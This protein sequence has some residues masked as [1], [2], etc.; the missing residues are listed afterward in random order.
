MKPTDREI[1]VPDFEQMENVGEDGGQT[2]MSNCD[3]TVGEGVE[4]GLR[5]GKW[6]RYAGWNFNGL[7]WFA[8]GQFH[9][10]PWTYH[11]PQAVI[12]ADTIKG[13]MEAVSD[14]YGY[15]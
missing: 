10:Q 5:A 4:E 1:A 15:D 9:C 8:D 13:L 6:T 14:V 3:F 7:C 2:G 11:V 12:S